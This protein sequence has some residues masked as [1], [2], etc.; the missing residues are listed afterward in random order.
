[1]LPR[2]PGT[3]QQKSSDPL[4]LDPAISASCCWMYPS[5]STPLTRQIL[6]ETVHGADEA[7]RPEYKKDPRVYFA[8]AHPVLRTAMPELFKGM[9]VELPG[10][11]VMTTQ[12]LQRRAMH[13]ME[14][15]SMA[16]KVVTVAALPW[17]HWPCSGG[18]SAPDYGTG[19]TIESGSL[20]RGRVAATEI[21]CR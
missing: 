15:G 14:Y 18:L 4:R 21:I 20:L 10:N 12:Q 7:A 19:K 5:S 11:L 8:P 2:A 17:R 13:N 6:G 9:G 16:R 1:M 3:G